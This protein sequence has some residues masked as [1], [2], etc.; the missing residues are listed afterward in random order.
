MGSVRTPILRETSTSTPQ[1]RAEQTYTLNYDEPLNVSG[2]N[3][4]EASLGC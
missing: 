3:T 1:R 4:R 2:R